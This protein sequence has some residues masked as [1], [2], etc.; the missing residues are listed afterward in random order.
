MSDHYAV[1]NRLGN[2]P[3]D[4]AVLEVAGDAEAD[5]SFSVF[6]STGSATR[7]TG[8][9]KP[10]SFFVSS[11]NLL[12][13]ATSDTAL[14][15]ASYSAGASTAVL[16]QMS[17][18][19]KILVEVR[20]FDPQIAR[21]FVFPLGD[22]GRGAWALV[23]NTA[24]PGTVGTIT[25]RYGSSTATPVGGG[26]VPGR[27]AV[28]VPLTVPNTQVWLECDAPVVVMLALDTGKV[29]EA[30]IPPIG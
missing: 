1:I 14:V 27:G 16:R 21:K 20:P 26:T 9:I 19:G 2:S 12:S 13:S 30:W 11:P 24:L 7:S 25:L 18:G 4:S 6:S 22:I 15:Q 8:S 28:A 10:P 29:D 17:A 3:R 23:G 5:V